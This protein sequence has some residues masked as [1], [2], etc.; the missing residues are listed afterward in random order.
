M[1]THNIPSCKRKSKDFPIL[2]PVLA[3]CLTLTSSN[4]PYLEHISM[5]SKVF[6]PLKFYCIR[7][8]GRIAENHSAE[9]KHHISNEL[10]LFLIYRRLSR[11]ISES[12][13]MLSAL[14]LP[15]SHIYTY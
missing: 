2:P 6:K 15:C 12:K 11:H 9:N 5:L 10:P 14:E 1:R 8:C 7:L 4:Y 13:S 3:L